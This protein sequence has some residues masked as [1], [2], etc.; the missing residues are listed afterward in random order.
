MIGV[1]LVLAIAI[2]AGLIFGTITY[3]LGRL[4]DRGGQQ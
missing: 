1:G 3:L 4:I 2:P